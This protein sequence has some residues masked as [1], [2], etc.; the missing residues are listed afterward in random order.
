MTLSKEFAAG[1]MILVGA[2]ALSSAQ[3]NPCATGGICCE[4]CTYRCPGQSTCTSNC[5]SRFERD[6]CVDIGNKNADAAVV[7]ACG[8]VRIACNIP[9]TTEGPGIDPEALALENCC[10]LT[11][12][13]CAALG[14]RRSCNLGTFGTCTEEEFNHHFAYNIDFAC[15]AR[16]CHNPE[17]LEE[18]IWDPRCAV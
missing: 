3:I 10:S 9:Q 17:C 8:A 16:T 6:G 5:Q 7:L 4:D 2:L 18:L 1:T 12:D 13:S 14:S 15:K 11:L